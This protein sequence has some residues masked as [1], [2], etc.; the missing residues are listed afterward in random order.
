VGNEN[1]KHFLEKAGKNATYTSKD[2]VID[3]VETIGQWIENLLK[4]LHRAEY[5]SLL[6][7][8]RTDTY[9]FQQLK[10]FL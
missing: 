10:N 8:E 4:R 6:V 5:F 1:L 3:F 9:V 7:D 2:A